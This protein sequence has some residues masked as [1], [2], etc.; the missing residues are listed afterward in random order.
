MNGC[1]CTRRPRV[2]RDSSLEADAPWRW[3]LRRTAKLELR[4][5]S[6]VKKF[7]SDCKAKVDL[8]KNILCIGCSKCLETD[9]CLQSQNTHMRGGAC[10]ELSF[11][12]ESREP[13]RRE[14][15]NEFILCKKKARMH[16]YSVKTMLRKKQSLVMYAGCQM[17]LFA[18][19]SW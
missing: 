3:H 7:R 2:I 4:D 16:L 14:S 10:I 11:L 18:Q 8:T 19:D 15:Q 9:Y 1:F 5:T 13:Q 12:A 17:S 6:E